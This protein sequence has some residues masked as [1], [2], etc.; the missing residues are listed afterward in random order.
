MGEYLRHNCGL[1]VAHTL[2]DAY[3]FIKSLQHRGREAAGIVAISEN[4]IDAM[5]WAGS[6][7][8]FD[9]TDLHK[10]FPS[11]SNNYHTYMAHV[12]YATRGRKDKILEDA[13]PHGIGGNVED[14][15]SHIF[16]ENCEMA[17]V[18]NGQVD[19]EF[20][21]ELNHI[22]F[23]SSCDT[24]ALLHLIKEKG[25]QYVLKYIP[26][27]F[28]LAF[29]DKRREGVVVMRDK[30]GMHPGVLGW[31]DG[32]YCAASEDIAIRK[33]GGE[34]KEEL[35]P[36][37]A[38]YLY[39]NGSYKKERIV[40]PNPKHCFFEYNYLSDIDSIM[41]RV[42][43]R[44]VEESLGE[45]LAQKFHPQDADYVTFLPRRPEVAAQ[46]FSNET[47]IPLIN[48]FYKMRKERSFQG[49]TQQER[50][51]SINENLHLLPEI[52][53]ISSKGFLRGKTI[54]LIDDSTIRGTNSQRAR[55]L[56]E[57]VK[58]KKAYLVN[59]TPQIGIIGE[60][61]I[62][63]GCT[64]GVDIPPDDNFIAR[65]RTIKEISEKIGMDVVYLSLEEMLSAFEKA[66]MPRQNLCTYCI[67][68][69]HPFNKL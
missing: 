61:G 14:R 21:Q 1:T 7:D 47:G 3:S 6:V 44:K 69:K 26:G 9:I 52:E 38:Y 39:P 24:E 13:H 19:S 5:K 57:K 15:G 66:G 49:S 16:I 59:Y 68:G 65:N 41:N 30:L 63:R 20:F 43:S 10:I 53:G 32:K 50:K 60:D 35:E 45:V 51:V 8:S 23:K 33:N 56:L 55:D 42:S 2:H 11:Y 22:N 62:P 67:G 4:R 36:G 40:Q 28:T 48:I 25:E 58:V 31:K 37:T 12:R 17:A 29:V 34:F 46:I 54:I 64:F 27:S 18:H